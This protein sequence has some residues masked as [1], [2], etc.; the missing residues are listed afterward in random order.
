MRQY[1]I[2]RLISK[3]VV[4]DNGAITVDVPRGYDIESIYFRLYGSFVIT[5]NFTA[6]RAE[7]PLQLIKRIELIADGKNTIDSVPF[8]LQNRAAVKRRGQLGALTPSAGFVIATNA[9]AAAAVIDKAMIDGIRPKDS[10]LRT[11]GMSLLQLRFT[12]GSVADCF[13]GAGVGTLL[14]AFCDVY[15]SEM[16]EI[17]NGDEKRTSPLYLIKRAYQDVAFAASN[18]AFDII[19]PVGNVMRG[20][21]LRSE[22]AVTAGEPSDAVINNVILRSNTDVRLN[23]PYLDLR[24]ANKQDFDITT[25]PTGICF[26][27]LMSFGAQAGVH[28]ADGWDL[29]GASDARVTLDVTG[30][31]NTKVSVL[32]E[33]LIR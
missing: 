17:P 29:T 16:V 3:T 22:G 19:L 21:F 20:V 1:R 31:A 8:V 25:L 2:K 14:N 6:V 12:F 24:E 33:E 11:D 23:L 10:N 32:T 9:F 5:T 26:A 30:A 4:T 27:D 13:T 15:T 28:A 18:A 7:N